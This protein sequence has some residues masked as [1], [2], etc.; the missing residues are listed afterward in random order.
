MTK[1]ERAKL[2]LALEQED[3]VAL[4]RIPKTDLHCHGLLSAPLEAY[5]L[6]ADQPLPAPPRSFGDFGSFGN[7]IATHL[8]PILGRGQDAVT[9]V[10]RATFERFAD[11]GVVYAE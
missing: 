4:A 9:A 8:L 1:D 7:Y 5:A 10:I 2:Q 3:R 11:D 6:M